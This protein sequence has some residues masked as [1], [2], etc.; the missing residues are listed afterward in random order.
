MKQVIVLLASIMLGL[1]IVKVLVIDDDSI[2]NSMKGLWE[3]E[4]M[5]RDMGEVYDETVYGNVCSVA[6]TISNY[7]ST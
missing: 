5:I 2:F 4:V 7:H 1:F 3:N 6:T